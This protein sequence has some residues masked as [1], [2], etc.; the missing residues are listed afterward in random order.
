VLLLVEQLL[1]LRSEQV[2]LRATCHESSIRGE[3]LVVLSLKF[4]PII[5]PH[6]PRVMHAVNPVQQL[7]RLNLVDK[8]LGLMEG[9]MAE[10]VG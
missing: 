1:L 7:V 6:N 10:K 2:A 4:L 9:V 5:N 8:A 3:Q